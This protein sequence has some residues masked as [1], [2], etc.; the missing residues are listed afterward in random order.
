MGHGISAV[1]LVEEVGGV[2]RGR[3]AIGFCDGPFGED[4]VGVEVLDGS[5][6]REVEGQRVDLN[7]V[8]GVLERN[9]LWFSDGMRAGFRR[10]FA[11]RRT[12][13][14]KTSD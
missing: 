3:A 6:G 12:K 4:I 10:R 5:A 9:V 1:T 7:D 2:G 14:P 13:A 11:P 8:A